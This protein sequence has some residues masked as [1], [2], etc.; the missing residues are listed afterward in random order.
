MNMKVN[1][2]QNQVKE[3]CLYCYPPFQSLSVV[4]RMLARLNLVR[5]MCERL[6]LVSRTSARLFIVNIASAKTAPCQKNMCETTSTPT[7]CN[8]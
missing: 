2:S 1:L 4:S 7:T 5:R 6:L 8:F 3:R